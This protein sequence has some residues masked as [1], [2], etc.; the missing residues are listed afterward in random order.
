MPTVHHGP[1]AA[2]CVVLLG[3]STA[4][5]MAGLSAG[6]ASAEAIGP[7]AELQQLKAERAA[8][9]ADVDRVSAALRDL[10]QVAQASSDGGAIAPTQA[11]R[12]ELR[13]NA[14]EEA[15]R[16]NTG[17]VETFGF[18][19]QQLENRVGSLDERLLSVERSQLEMG[20]GGAAQPA[21]DGSAPASAPASG[22]DG[23]AVAGLPQDPGSSIALPN[24]SPEE[25]YE[26]AFGLLRQA[27]YADAQSAL[28]QF[29]QGNAEHGL[30]GNAKYWLGETFYVRGDYQSS[31]LIFAEAYREYPDSQKAPDNLLK[32]GMSLANLGDIENAC[33]TLSELLRIYPRAASSIRGRAE[34][35]MQRME[36]P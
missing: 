31:A 29:L 4:V 11:A 17:Q 25:Q 2:K 15:L 20:D 1:W 36:C 35:E 26:F 18:R 22:G 21:A 30:A 32:L 12:F 5:L 23:Q 6:H 10:R 28:E 27:K 9:A 34:R 19:L 16:K 33:G 13:M 3:L 24:G 14:L 8:L 7:A